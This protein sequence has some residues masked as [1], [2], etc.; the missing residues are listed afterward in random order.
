MQ[1]SAPCVNKNDRNIRTA[2]LPRDLHLNSAR[3]CRYST[4]D[5]GRVSFS[6]LLSRCARRSTTFR[7]RAFRSTF[8]FRDVELLVWVSPSVRGDTRHVRVSSKRIDAIPEER[9]PAA[10]RFLARPCVGVLFSKQFFP[11]RRFDR[12]SDKHGK[13]CQRRLRC[14][15][16]G[17]HVAVPGGGT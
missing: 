2:G 7:R 14:T 12:R 9:H 15:H 11:P 3:K 1:L 16:Y 5:K 4:N 8:R 13:S 17:T 10:L 6:S